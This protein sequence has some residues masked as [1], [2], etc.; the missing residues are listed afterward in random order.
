MLIMLSNSYYICFFQI[1]CMV[2]KTQVLKIYVYFSEIIL[3]TGN[4]SC[5][6]IFKHFNYIAKKYIFNQS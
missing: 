3:K 5:I 2:I 1:L 6:I 4:F